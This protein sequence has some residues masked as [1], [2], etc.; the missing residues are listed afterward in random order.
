[1]Y[2]D[3]IVKLWDTFTEC[4]RTVCTRIEANDSYNT[5]LLDMA[6]FVSN[7][8][9]KALW[10]SLPQLGITKRWYVAKIAGKVEVF[11]NPKIEL[12]GFKKVANEACL[13]EPWIEKPIFRNEAVTVTYYDIFGTRKTLKL[14][15]LYARIVQHEHDHLDWILLVDK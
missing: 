4:L 9:N 12:R 7:S 8:D 13:S 2:I 1:M 11:I 3:H 10:L 5:L 14:A 6:E 15:W